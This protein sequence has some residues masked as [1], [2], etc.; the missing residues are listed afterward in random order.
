M[1]GI[2]TIRK[3][4]VI[5][6]FNKTLLILFQAGFNQLIYEAGLAKHIPFLHR[7]VH[8]RK[9]IKSLELPK[10]LREAL[11]K[12]GPVYIKFGQILSTRWD[13]LPKEYTDEFEKLQDTVPPFSYLEA[14][15]TIEESFGKPLHK[16]FHKFSR[17]PFA[18]ASLGQVYKA[19]LP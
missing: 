16:I 1:F 11:I 14:K 4:R 9:R 10:K 3:I 8:G 12:L 18:S 15:Q 5:V 2:K 19:K 17:K 7:I 13:I 6:R